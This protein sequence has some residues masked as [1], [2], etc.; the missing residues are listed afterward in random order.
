VELM[1]L[2]QTVRYRAAWTVRNQ[3]WSSFI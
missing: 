2:T 3:G 1:L